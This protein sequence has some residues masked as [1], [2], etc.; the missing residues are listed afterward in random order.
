MTN[1]SPPALGLRRWRAMVGD[2]AI[3]GLER[4]GVGAPVVLLHGW[5]AR[6]D[7]FTALLV[8]LRTPRPVWAPDLPGFGESPL[9]AG[10]W[11]TAAYA[12]LVRR[13][14]EEAGW[15]RVSLLGHSYGGGVAV[16]VAAGPG[17][18]VD[19][20]CLCDAAGLRLSPA[21]DVRRSRLAYRRR[22]R[23]GRLVPPR[24]RG[25][26]EARWRERYGSTDYRAAGPLRPTL[27]DAVNEDLAPVARTVSVPTL[28]LWGAQD[29]DLPV[30]TAAARY[31]ELIAGSELVVLERSGHFPFLDEPQRCAAIVDAFV[32]ARL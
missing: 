20:L 14:V 22:R 5:G 25:R 6:A 32:D 19:R 26:L 7:T 28:L 29:Q 10:G 12:A 8:R 24:W 31:R 16:R 30:A 13:W 27:V 4:P 18:P 15:D 1:A 11:T 23:L 17:A 21:A 2:A 9:G 3:A